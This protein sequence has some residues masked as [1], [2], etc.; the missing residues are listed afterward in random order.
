M[1]HM[2]SPGKNPKEF[3]PELDDKTV[4]FLQKA[5]ERDPKDRFQTATEFR[6]ALKAL[7][8]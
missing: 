6:D 8:K 5:I 1:S 4:K 3:R 2:N 7:Q